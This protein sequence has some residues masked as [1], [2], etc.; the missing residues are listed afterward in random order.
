MTEQTKP[1]M[2][3]VELPEPSDSGDERIDIPEPD[4]GEG[5]D[6]EDKSRERR[7]V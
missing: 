2:P 7:W 4:S 5:P 3:E 1:T 6:L